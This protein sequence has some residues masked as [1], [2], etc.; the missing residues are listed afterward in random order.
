MTSDMLCWPGGH[1]STASFP[2]RELGLR[3]EPSPVVVRPYARYGRDASA[4]APG[5]TMF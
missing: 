4:A 3:K 5:S 1:V 2:L